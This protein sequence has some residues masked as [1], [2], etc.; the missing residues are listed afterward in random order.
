MDRGMSSGRR[1]CCIWLLQQSVESR[2]CCCAQSLEGLGIGDRLRTIRAKMRAEYPQD[3]R[4]KMRKW[5][6]ARRSLME[7]AHWSSEDIIMVRPAA[8]CM[9]ARSKQ[10]VDARRL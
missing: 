4:N 5:S 6:A 9:L 2:G 1:A 8:P 3:P 7:S 10:W